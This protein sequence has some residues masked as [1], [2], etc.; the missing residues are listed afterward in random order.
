[1][2]WITKRWKFL[3]FLSSVYY[4]YCT[5]SDNP[6]LSS[7]IQ[8]NTTSQTTFP[9]Q[10][11]RRAIRGQTASYLN[12]DN[13]PPEVRRHR[14]WIPTTLLYCRSQ[15]TSHRRSDG[16]LPELRR[17]SI[18]SQ[19]TSHRRSDA[20]LPELND[21]PLE[22]RQHPI[23]G[24]TTS[25]LNSDSILAEVIWHLNW[26]QTTCHKKSDDTLPAFRGDYP[27]KIQTTSTKS[28]N[29]SK[30]LVKW[31]REWKKKLRTN[32]VM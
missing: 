23:G 24:Q 19:T 6:A 1:M 11:W 14:T 20:I 29:T 7:S 21:I 5:P 32:K 15:T 27:N 30:T 22:V 31:K 28:K 8:K 12:S 9:H 2:V 16:I 26:I 10:F 18:G 3:Q 25:C 17:H 4:S 13:I